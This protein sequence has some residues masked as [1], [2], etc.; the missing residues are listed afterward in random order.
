MAM[1]AGS[2]SLR[3][4][5]V[6]GALHVIEMCSEFSSAAIIVIINII[7][8]GIVYALSL[9]VAL[10]GWRGQKGNATRIR[11]RRMITFGF[12]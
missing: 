2:L 10:V 7:P 6:L 9:C 4:R 8:F 11:F 5:S 1:N 12:A 3:S